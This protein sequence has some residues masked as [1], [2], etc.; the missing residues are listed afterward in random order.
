MTILFSGWYNAGKEASVEER[1]GLML[2]KN[3]FDGRVHENFFKLLSCKNRIFYSD[4]VMYLH[5][6]VSKNID[7]MPKPDVLDVISNCL[8]TY[9]DAV[10]AEEDDF[11]LGETKRAA[12]PLTK[13]MAFRKMRDCGWLVTEAAEDGRTVNV[14]FT[15]SAEEQI[16]ALRRMSTEKKHHLGGYARSIQ[17]GLARAISPS[18]KKPFQDALYGVWENARQFSQTIRAIR[19]SLSDEATKLLNVPGRDYDETLRRFNEYMKQGLEGD[20]YQ[21]QI[22]EGVN[23]ELVQ[24]VQKDLDTINFRSEDDEA[25]V[26]L[27][28]RLIDDIMDFYPDIED[29]EEAR[30]TL[31]DCLAA[32][33][34]AIG[35]AFEEKMKGIQRTQ[36]L[37]LNNVMTKIT[38]MCV[39]DN[40][41]E[42]DV[43]SLALALGEMD[44]DTYEVWDEYRTAGGRLAPLF[45][46]CVGF[47]LDEDSL[48]KPRA[49]RSTEVIE[50][51][52][53]AEPTE[54]ICFGEDDLREINP[55]LSAKNLNRWVS[56]LLDGRSSMRSEELKIESE[57]EF[58]NLVS[59]A[60]SAD[61][62]LL[63]YEAVFDEEQSP[64]RMGRFTVPKFSI[65]P[66]SRASS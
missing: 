58:E 40:M 10:K 27:Y 9:G 6:Y 63:E 24:S 47:F 19:N 65:V 62:A 2:T 20:L 21:L 56:G 23:A 52:A 61:N 50:E 26:G 4:C 13:D 39:E 30:D 12:V 18:T 59:M 51:V 49:A 31:D 28:R 38:M 8:A 41:V 44:D 11:D 57:E 54:E 15:Q 66:R 33:R 45:Q 35:P 37:L 64:V 25:E 22:A 29:E 42:K 53:L 48:A 36:S 60:I 32:I 3:I 14:F 16:L 17:D 43:N 46:P 7:G 34:D 1:G 55:R 5:D